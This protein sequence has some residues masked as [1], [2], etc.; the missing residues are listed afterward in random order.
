MSNIGEI[1]NFLLKNGIDADAMGIDIAQF[2]SGLVDAKENGEKPDAGNILD[3]VSGI[4][5]NLGG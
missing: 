1:K 5:G 4:L 2:I 3:E